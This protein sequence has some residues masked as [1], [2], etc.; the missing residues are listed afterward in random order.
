MEEIKAVRLFDQDP[1][2][3]DEFG[4]VISCIRFVCVEDFGICYANSEEYYSWIESMEKENRI[5][6]ISPNNI[7][8]K[9]FRE[10]F[11][12]GKIEVEW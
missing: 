7:P 8:R 12:K 2:I 10:H 3:Y 6:I 4:S 9:V 1:V 5:V 11:V